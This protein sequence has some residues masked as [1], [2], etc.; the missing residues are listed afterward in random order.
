MS[1]KRVVE[2]NP[3]SPVPEAR[4]PL[5]HKV[6]QSWNIMK[7]KIRATNMFRVSGTIVPKRY[8]EAKF[9]SLIRSWTTKSGPL[10]W[11]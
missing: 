1:P 8:S 10:S 6:T 5:K 3:P 4:V 2:E 7:W 11:T 9:A